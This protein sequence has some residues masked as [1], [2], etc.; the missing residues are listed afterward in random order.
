VSPVVGATVGHGRT[1]GA[2]VGAGP[3]ATRPAATMVGAGETA[4][5]AAARTTMGRWRPLRA[6]AAKS[7]VGWLLIVTWQTKGERGKTT[8]VRFHQ[9]THET[10]RHIRIVFRDL[11]IKTSKAHKKCFKTSKDF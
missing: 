10:I 6:A 5:A 7:K 1:G 2:M 9:K 8:G 3:T 4:A 11:H